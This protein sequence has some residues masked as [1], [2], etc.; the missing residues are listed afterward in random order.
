MTFFADL[1]I[2]LVASLNLFNNFFAQINSV[3]S[4]ANP[5]GIT[6][7]AGPGVKNKIHPISTI[8]I[9]IKKIAN[10]FICLYK[11]SGDIWFYFGSVTPICF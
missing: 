5:A 4:K 11:T 10:L 3:A 1:D 8:E 7:I 2:E 9:P 6:I